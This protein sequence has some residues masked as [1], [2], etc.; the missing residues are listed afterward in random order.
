VIALLGEK[1]E[2]LVCST[3]HPERAARAIKI[4]WVGTRRWGG[5]AVSS[6]G[7]RAVVA[8]AYA[9]TVDV[10]TGKSATID[11][12]SD[13]ILNGDPAT[14]GRT[15]ALIGGHE[16]LVWDIVSH[17]LLWKRTVDEGDVAYKTVSCVPDDRTIV[18]T[19]VQGPI[20]VFDVASERARNR[21]LCT[22]SSRSTPTAARR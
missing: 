8:G 15:A 5:L 14:N 6:D 22:A 12:V 4:P 19:V 9:T 21:A 11:W 10:V 17:K 1:R 16:L 18:V 7:R 2:L 3:D 20:P 13:D